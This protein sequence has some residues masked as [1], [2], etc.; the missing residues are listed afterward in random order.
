MSASVPPPAAS[1]LRSVPFRRLLLGLCLAGLCGP[2]VGCVH[3]RMTIRSDPPGALVLL[4]G[5]EIG[6]TPTAV[7]FTYYGTR[8]ITLVKDGYET[9]TTL[10]RVKSPWYQYFPID[11]VSDNLLP[12]KVNDRHDFTYKL[13]PSVMVPTREL[14]ERGN[15]LR[16]E[17][18]M[19]PWGP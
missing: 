3:R 1:P 13:R 16:T 18:Q 19:G 14:L 5:E 4:D 12:C 11:F 9:L 8:E 15:G 7:D 2:A 10:Q 17:S 6:Y